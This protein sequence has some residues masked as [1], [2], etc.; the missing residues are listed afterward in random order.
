MSYMYRSKPEIL[1]FQP[2]PPFIFHLQSL[3]DS[4]KFFKYDDFNVVFK[5]LFLL[6]G[7]EEKEFTGAGNYEYKE[8]DRMNSCSRLSL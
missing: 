7:K 2:I 8:K 4:L 1:R 6:F 5:C 3:K